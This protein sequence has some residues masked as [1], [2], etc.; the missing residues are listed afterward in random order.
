[1]YKLT[2]NG[3]DPASLLPL[4]SLLSLLCQAA[5]QNKNC[6]QEKNLRANESSNLLDLFI[7]LKCNLLLQALAE[8]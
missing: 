4:N 5:S 3:K 6:F 2:G 1:V 7:S 8:I